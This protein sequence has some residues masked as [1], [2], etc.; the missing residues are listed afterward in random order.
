[1][2]PV[3][4]LLHPEL[5]KRTPT[6]SETAVLLCAHAIDVLERRVRALVK[7]QDQHTEQLEQVIRTIDEIK[8]SDD[9]V[10]SFRADDRSFDELRDL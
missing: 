1:M 6:T 3:D 2:N 7:I 8:H 5:M 4:E 9:W 10:T